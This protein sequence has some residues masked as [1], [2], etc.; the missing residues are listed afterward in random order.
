MIG[1]SQN[2]LFSFMNCQS[3]L[4]T[5]TFDIQNSSKHLFVV[6]RVAL[7]FGIGPPIR[8]AWVG[9]TVEWIPSHC[10]LDQSDRSEHCEEYKRQDDSRCNVGQPFSQ[11]HPRLIW[12]D[13]RPRENQAE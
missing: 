13:Q 12:E 8:L 10:P 11:S 2:F 5:C 4:T 6:T 1:A 7:P 9:A 3:S